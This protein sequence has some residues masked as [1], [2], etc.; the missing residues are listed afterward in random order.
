ME[1][2]Q[3]QGIKS[4]G[5]NADSKDDRTK[6]IRC[7]LR[8]AEGFLYPLDKAFYFLSNKPVLIEL[9][10]V[11]SVEFNRVD[12]AAST[13]AARTFDITVHMKDMSSNLQFV[14]LNR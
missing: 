11:A 1:W 7:S 5:F 14:N 4:G 2:S 8:A 9:D 3:V 6:S 10:R 12:K 13:A